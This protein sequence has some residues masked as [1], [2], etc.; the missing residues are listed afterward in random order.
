MSTPVCLSDG[1]LS[2]VMNAARPLAP[3]DPGD[4]SDA[5]RPT[6]PAHRR[7]AV[8]GVLTPR[9]PAPGAREGV[10][11]PPPATNPGQC[12]AEMDIG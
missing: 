3:R 10:L 12:S 6:G 1:E 4:V 11:R 7:A 9:L 8:A 2:A 5:L